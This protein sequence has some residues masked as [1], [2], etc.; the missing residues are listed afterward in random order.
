MTSYFL[1]VG[2]LNR[3]CVIVDLPSIQI[4]VSAL[5]NEILGPLRSLSFRETRN[6]E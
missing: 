4:V 2:V 6:T 5:R 3:V 1:L